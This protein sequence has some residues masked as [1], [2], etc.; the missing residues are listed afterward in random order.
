MNIEALEPNLD[1]IK[2]SLDFVDLDRM[3]LQD[4]PV[5]MSHPIYFDLLWI[6]LPR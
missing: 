1:L 5:I 2:W 6:I 4:D 3:D